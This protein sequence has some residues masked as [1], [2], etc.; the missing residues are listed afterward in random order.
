MSTEGEKGGQKGKKFMNF[1]FA[2]KFTYIYIYIYRVSSKKK[3]SWFLAQNFLLAS[4][5]N[6]FSVLFERE[7]FNN[8]TAEFSN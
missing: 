7:R 1:N 4:D 5:K 3:T 6:K 2:S 8:C